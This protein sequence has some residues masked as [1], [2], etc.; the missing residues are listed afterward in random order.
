MACAASILVAL[1]GWFLRSARRRRMT[2]A[3]DFVPRT[4]MRSAATMVRP[5]HEV[6]RS[7]GDGGD[8]ERT[9]SRTLEGEDPAY[10]A[11]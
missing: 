4:D 9:P 1:V 3:P 8:P 11:A 10:S 5:G 2:R 6:V 7:D